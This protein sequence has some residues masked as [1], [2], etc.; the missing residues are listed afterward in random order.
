MLH[1]L[2][3]MKDGKNS[4]KNTTPPREYVLTC[5]NDIFY[6]NQYELSNQMIKDALEGVANGTYDILRFA[7]LTSTIQVLATSS[8]AEKV[9]TYIFLSISL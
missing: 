9:R 3:L 2:L 8:S 5:D 7:H 6:L 4:T 1:C